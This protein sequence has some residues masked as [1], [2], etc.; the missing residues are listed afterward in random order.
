MVIMAPGFL[1]KPVPVPI[2]SRWKIENGQWC[3]YIDQDEINTTPF[4][5]MKAGTAP[6]GDGPPAAIPSQEEAMKMLAAVKAEHEEAELKIRE[7]STAEYTIVNGLPG[8]VTL[9][10]E[11]VLFPGITATL[12][13]KELAAGQKAHVNVEWHPSAYV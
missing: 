2:P 8:K 13:P 4:G 3:W 1:G 5:R 7:V 10:L 12:E 9:S 11:P 6:A